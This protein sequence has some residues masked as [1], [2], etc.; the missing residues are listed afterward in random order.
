MNTVT[1]VERE[2]GWAFRQLVDGRLE[3]A[4]RFSNLTIEAIYFRVSP[5]EAYEN[6]R[7]AAH[8]ALS[9]LDLK[10]REERAKLQVA[11]GLTPDD[12]YMS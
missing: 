11:L 8:F 3:S 10:Q 6:A 4:R 12:R 7:L 1:S 9:Y 2:P 5:K